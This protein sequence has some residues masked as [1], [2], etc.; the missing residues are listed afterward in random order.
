[1]SRASE[2]AKQR[3]LSQTFVAKGY[4]LDE[5]R[6]KITKCKQNI[7]KLQE[8]I[9]ARDEQ[10]Q[11]KT[12]QMLANVQTIKDI[13]EKIAQ[14][15]AK[16]KVLETEE[17]TDADLL[18]RAAGLEK[19]AGSR[20]IRE[21]GT[22]LKSVNKIQEELYTDGTG[23]LLAGPM[24][25]GAGAGAGAGAGGDSDLMTAGTMD[26]AER[27]KEI[28]VV[29]GVNSCV[30]PVTP[31]DTFG[32]LLSKSIV[33]WSLDPAQHVLVDA[34]D[35]VWPS[36]LLV[37]RTLADSE[38]TTVKVLSRPNPDAA[39]TKDGK[40]EESVS[41]EA[42]MQLE[43][44][45][46]Q[47]RERTGKGGG[48]IDN[49]KKL[50]G[51][52]QVMPGVNLGDGDRV[53]VIR[54]MK[55]RNPIS[56]RNYADLFCFLIFAVMFVNT[57]FMRM[58]IEESYAVTHGIRNA[59]FDRQFPSVS[60]TASSVVTS[61]ALQR[62]FISFNEIELVDQF[63]LW[64]ENPVRTLLT[65]SGLD[66]F[67]SLTSLS[68]PSSL[69]HNFTIDD[70]TRCCNSTSVADCDV[71]RGSDVVC[72]LVPG[73]YE[74]AN[75]T[76]NPVLCDTAI[77][78]HAL[79][80]YNYLHGG[81]HMRQLRVRNDSCTIPE[82]YDK[83]M[84]TCYAA[85]DKA[86]SASMDTS[87][88]GPGG[89]GFTYTN[90]IGG[91]TLD[92]STVYQTYSVPEERSLPPGL[93]VLANYDTGGY[94]TFLPSEEGAFDATVAYLKSNEWIDSQTRGVV[95]S[96]NFYNANFDVVAVTAVLFEFSPSGAVIPQKSIKA[97]RMNQ[98]WSPR[99]ETRVALEFVCIGIVAWLLIGMVFDVAT[100]GFS[101]YIGVSALRDPGI[102]ARLQMER[103]KALQSSVDPT[104][105]L[106][107]EEEELQRLKKLREAQRRGE[108]PP[109]GVVEK[110]NTGDQQY[111][112][113]KTRAS[114]WNLML[115]ALI[116]FASL[117]FIVRRMFLSEAD[118]VT[119]EFDAVPP[120]PYVDLHRL[121][122]L[123]RVSVN[124]DALTAVIVF[125]QL[126]KFFN[127]NPYMS[128]VWLVIGE[129]GPAIINYLITFV[130]MLAAFTVAGHVLFGHQLEDYLELDRGFNTL[131][132]MLVGNLDYSQL[133]AVRGVSA[134]LFFA[135][136]MVL[137][138]FIASNLYLAI[139]N[140]AYTRVADG[141]RAR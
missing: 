130:I 57:L 88:F 11:H 66:S 67:T 105:R 77:G 89:S 93:G 52:L 125:L 118:G 80:R 95:L 60:S 14:W 75:S 78:R 65:Q 85:F 84:R 32:S 111:A 41:R 83:F 47:G 36:E 140:A 109:E 98:D 91:L 82:E 44:R 106:K 139:M 27:F 21:M 29:H 10:I 53:S 108:D 68:C 20:L 100:L 2:K 117:G 123:Y 133:E 34:Q 12:D 124:L 15:K 126:F 128:M 76:S 61:Q 104:V 86:D 4:E 79:L 129:A 8:D 25:G 132:R 59:V 19:D 40:L 74:D 56:V 9:R 3:Q 94:D 97:M 127:L 50:F 70:T 136:F 120:Q 101:A 71:S 45:K 18:E 7:D 38:D 54:S 46:R 115:I 73:T 114:A 42:R 51:K 116:C 28:R 63:W 62:E 49:A 58:A 13:D 138:F 31:E 24:G 33:Y 131:L 23:G 43:E 102:A 48:M 39:E 6:L 90:V 112:M 99:D 122:W 121:A 107:E 135:A 35:H 1:M 87:A 17:E 30:F 64:I 69:P 72:T 92:N 22:I 26:P 55:L 110:V 103:K 119:M 96:F 134:G 16:I 81:V 113:L 141:V 137:G 37:Q 5:L